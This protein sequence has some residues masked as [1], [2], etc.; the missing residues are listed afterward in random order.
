MIK[1]QAILHACREYNTYQLLTFIS[2]P[3]NL[4]FSDSFVQ[5]CALD[6]ETLKIKI[7]LGLQLCN[8]LLDTARIMYANTYDS[9]AILLLI[10]LNADP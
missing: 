2:A 7:V 10:S 5:K 4:N 9:G 3:S 6:R 8:F 1:F